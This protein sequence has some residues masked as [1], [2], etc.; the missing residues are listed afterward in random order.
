MNLLQELKTLNDLDDFYDEYDDLRNRANE[1]LLY[2]CN[3]EAVGLAV[4]A[5]KARSLYEQKLND[6]ILDLS[7]C[8]L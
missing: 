6:Y 7:S 3:G 4:M 8:N 2:G 1:A 5:Y